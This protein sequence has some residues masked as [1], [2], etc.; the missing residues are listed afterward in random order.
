VVISRSP[1][2][3]RH[4]VCKRVLGKGGDVLAVP[5]AGG[6]LRTRT[7]LTLNELNLLLLFRAS[8]CPFTLND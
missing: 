5:K 2:N 6:L 7:R 3:P 4:T 8:V 1:T